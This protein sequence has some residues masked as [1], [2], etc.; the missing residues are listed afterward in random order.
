MAIVLLSSDL[1]FPDPSHANPDGLLAVG[2]DLS[3]ERLLVAY[4]SGIF[5][6]FNAGDP[7]LWWSPDPRCVLYPSAVKISRSMR[8]V[9][10]RGMFEI[11]YDEAFS[12]VV[13]KCGSLRMHRE[14]TWITPDMV[15][16]YERLH[17]M[18]LAH[19]VE[20]YSKGILCGGL[21][22]VSLGGIFFGESMF[23]EMANA[24]KVAL[25][26]LCQELKRRNFGFIDCQL[27]TDHLISMGAVPI[28]REIYLESLQ[29]ELCKETLTGDWSAVFGQSE[30]SQLC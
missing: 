3:P 20:V 13:R 8:N 17:E 15:A 30:N 25:I 19:S 26:S 4:R 10:N 2:G 7:I 24:S 29:G 22:G 14:G 6:W 28:H 11:K 27:P 12:Q 9:L 1:E 18:G 21:Y 5:P 16:A 23:S